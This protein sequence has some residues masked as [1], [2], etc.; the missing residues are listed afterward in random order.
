MHRRIL[1]E[2]SLHETK[3][4]THEDNSTRAYTQA[5]SPEPRNPYQDGRRHSCTTTMMHPVHDR[6]HNRQLLARFQQKSF[7]SSDIDEHS[8][9]YTSRPCGLRRGLTASPWRFT[10]NSQHN[11]RPPTGSAAAQQRV[12]RVTNVLSAPGLHDRDR[13]GCEPR[14]SCPPVPRE[15]VPAGRPCTAEYTQNAGYKVTPMNDHVRLPF[16][17]R[18][19]ASRALKA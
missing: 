14:L 3:A 13:K 6:V 4:T 8:P 5:S 12:R 19:H 11:V 16:E 7:A 17:S 9:L 2:T 10:P 15:F 18:K 1:Q